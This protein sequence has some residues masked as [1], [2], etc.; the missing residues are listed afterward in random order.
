MNTVAV[1]IPADSIELEGELTI[2]S[3]AS[4]IVVFAH[5]SGSSRFSPRNSFVAQM[6]HRHGMATLLFDLLTRDENQDYS[7]RFDI[8]LLTYRLIAATA[9]LRINPL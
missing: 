2:P 6:L 8:D 4:G 1:K 3:T 5:G 7:T 9:W